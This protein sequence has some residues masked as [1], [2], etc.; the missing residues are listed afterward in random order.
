M[1]SDLGVNCSVKT[2]PEANVNLLKSW[3]CEQMHTIPQECIIYCGLYDIFEGVS[4]EN[5]L[6]SFG[7][8]INNLRAKNSNMEIYIC[9]VSPVPSPLEI[10]SGDGHSR[11]V[12]TFL[13]PCIL[14]L[15]ALT[16]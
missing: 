9:Q 10:P 1:Q 2:I 11:R 14:S 7:L 5:I 12:A 3:V 4:P 8:L 15:H 16:P 6:N 13:C